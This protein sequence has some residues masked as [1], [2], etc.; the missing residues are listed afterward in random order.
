MSDPLI[1]T[2]ANYGKFLDAHPDAPVCHILPMLFKLKG[3]PYN[4]ME[5]HFPFEPIFKLRRVPR[6]MILRAG[7]QVSKSTSLAALGIIYAAANPYFNLLTV[8]P[9]FE[10]IRKFSNNY[11]RPFIKDSTMKAMLVGDG[12][13][14]SVLQR[15]LAN[16]A[17]LFY[18]YS[19]GGDPGRVRGVSA[20]S[21]IV[22]EIQDFDMDSL[23]VIEATMSASTFKIVRYS[24][25][26]KT[27][28]N[29]LQLYWE[30]S[31]Q[32]IWHIPHGCGKINRCSVDSTNGDLLKMID[33]PKTLVCAR[34]GDPLD[35]T[36]GYY[37]HGYPERMN[38][39]PGYHLPQVIFPMHYGTPKDWSIIQEIRRDKPKYILY[40]EVLG[41]S[42]DVGLNMLTIEEIRAA[43]I[44]PFKQP[45]EIP[46]NK[47]VSIIVGVDWGGK[48]KEKTVDTEEFISN[49]A[50]A[51]AGLL[52]DGRVEIPYLFKTPYEATHYEEAVLA[53][54]VVAGCHADWIAHDFGGAGDVR[55]SILNNLGVPAG[56]ICP[57]T[58]LNVSPNKPI[59]NYTAPS[60]KGVRGSYILD[61]TR[62][63]MLFCALVKSGLVLLPNYEDAKLCLNDLTAIFEEVVERPRGNLKLVRRKR[64]RTD[65]I[66]HACNFAVMT[67]YH[68]QQMWPRLADAFQT[69]H[70]DMET[71][72][73]PGD[74]S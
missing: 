44:I 1:V 34:C 43:A 48:G 39:F 26:P 69:M 4:V 23:P 53:K 20:D 40:N 36:Q 61:K 67:L 24:G 33:N 17:N 13:A 46:T 49:T 66:V 71:S 30:K 11:V 70:G 74:L 42:I 2:L 12:D 68:S 16:G 63:L 3:K 6:R 47:Y 19:S 41:E 29:P 52:P 31:S 8:T 65:D 51:V 15:T 54:D 73:Q 64:R 37:V 21:L 25:T 57:F 50:I 35:S 56:M 7:R 59:V 45:H 62:S 9:L 22:D 55:E 28:D 58:Y 18:S 27:M 10:Q 5:S 60:A 32:G 38:D 14:G 72:W